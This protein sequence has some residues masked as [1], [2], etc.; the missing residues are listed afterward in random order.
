MANR[1]IP[2]IDLVDSFGCSA[3]ASDRTLTRVLRHNRRT[4][5][6]YR[7]W[8]SQQGLFAGDR[9]RLPR[10]GAPAAT[11]PAPP[12]PQQRS[13]VEA[14]REEIV[15][16]RARGLEAAAI[17][18]RLEETHRHPASYTAVGGCSATPRGVRRSYARRGR[19]RCARRGPARQRGA[20]GLWL[21]RA[22][23]RPTQRGRAQDLG[24]RHGA[25]LQP[26]PLRRTGLRPTGRDL[27]V[28]PRACFS[29]SSA[30][31]HSGWCPTTSRRR[32]PR[33]LHRAEA[34]RVPRMRRT[35]RLPH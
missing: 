27:V 35:L 28:V 3:G 8:A 5:A 14:Y 13:T 33:Q 20:G 29:P 34:N 31:C 26:A 9:P 6:K 24:L 16:P 25:G 23:H 4:I 1:S 18:V 7:D 22:E 10:A 21:C 2:I 32:C 19:E 11:L 17:R 30:V 12:P 15:A